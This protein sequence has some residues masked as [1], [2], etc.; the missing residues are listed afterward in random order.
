MGQIYI[1]AHKAFTAPKDPVYLP[2][3]LGKAADKGYDGAAD[4]TGDNI[5][6]KNPCYCELTGLYWAWKNAPRSDFVGLV[7][8]RRYLSEAGSKQ[9]LSG[10]SAKQLMSE[11][12]IVLPKKRNYY[13]ETC[14]SQYKHAH[15]I[16]DLDRARQIVC[17]MYPVYADS[18]DRVMAQ[19]SIYI[20]N[21]FIMKQ[22]LFEDYCQWLFPV[23]FELEKSIDISNYNTYNKRVFGFIAE[24]LFNVWLDYR[25]L[26]YCELSVVFTEKQ[27]L[28][29]KCLCFIGRKIVGGRRYEKK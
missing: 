1:A 6:G 17:E 23:L 11:Y 22:R 10:D 27:H 12:D 24:R 15:N 7:H 14:Y 16:A 21:M 28:I 4:N 20:H 29:W 9:I 13:I 26:K 8:Y 3:F 25:Q 19:R 18:F 5:S 2:I